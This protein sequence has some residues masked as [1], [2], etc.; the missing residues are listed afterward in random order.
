MTG[1]NVVLFLHVTSVIVMF[2]CLGADWVA[3][4]GLRSARTAGQAEPWVRT[5]EVSASIGPWAR[6]AVLGAGLFLA[7]DAWSWQG[8]IIVGLA[9]WVAYVVLGEPLT[10]RELRE[11]G[12]LVRSADGDLSPVATATLRHPRMWNAVLVRAGLGAGIVFCMVTKPP[13]PAAAVAVILG[14]AAGLV[15]AR[16]T[17]KPARRIPTTHQ[18]S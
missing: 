9:G 16:L 18:A 14:A 4:G 8:W 5:L 12:A 11:V 3:I 1:Y 13:A 6:L 2:G 17:T 7:I 10:G 15:A